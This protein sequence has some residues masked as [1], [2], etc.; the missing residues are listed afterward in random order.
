M[1]AGKAA[2]A[3][4]RPG[5]EQRTYRF[6]TCR[7]HVHGGDATCGRFC[8]RAGITCP[9]AR[10]EGSRE[11]RRP[12]AELRHDHPAWRGTAGPGVVGADLACEAILLVI[13]TFGAS[14]YMR[15][16]TTPQVSCRNDRAI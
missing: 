2:P 5:T 4:D 3:D 9:S 10:S 12:V 1:E 16:I 14:Q 15:H 6:S 13:P 11:S 7:F 8:Y